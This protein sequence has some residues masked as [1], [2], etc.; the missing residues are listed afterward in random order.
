MKILHQQLKEILHYDPKSGAFWWKKA[1][2]HKFYGG[3]AGHDCLDNG[4]RVVTIN[5]KNYM[6][7]RLA[8]F[9]VK[10]VWPSHTIHHKNGVRSDNRIHNLEDVPLAEN[11]KY[12]EKGRMSLSVK[13]TISPRIFIKRNVRLT[14]EI[15]RELLIYQPKTGQLFWRKRR[16]NVPKGKLAGYINTYG[17]R[18]L[19][20]AVGGVNKRYPAHRLIWLYVHGRLPKVW[21]DHINGN[22]GDNRLVNLR[23]ATPTQNHANKRRMKNNTSGFKGVCF[24]KTRKLWMASFCADYKQKNLGRFTTPEAAH[25]AYMAA[26]RKYHG[27]FARAA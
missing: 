3:R 1:V 15:V 16:S 14:A 23:E 25:E 18:I 7:H 19:S 24:D 22:K 10:G 8:W 20:I 27:E 6:E 26:A 5:K 17:Y 13:H 4:Y 21:I 2:P 11:L 9:Y 12:R